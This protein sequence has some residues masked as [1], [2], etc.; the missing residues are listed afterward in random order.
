MASYRYERDIDPKDLKPYTERTYTRR[1]RWANWWDYNLK[2]V[3]I[4]GIALAFVLYSFIGHY[5]FTVHPDYNVGVVSPY[6]LPEDTTNALQ[7]AL[8]AYG[9]DLNGD[10]QVVVTVNVYTLNYSSDTETE[11][12]AYLT[13]AGTTKLAADLQSALSGIF[14][15]YDPAGFEESTGT[16][17]YLDGSLPLAESDDDWWNMVYRWTD[18]PVLTGLDLGS[19]GQDAAQASSGDS[20][21]YLSHFYVG[22]RGV[23]SEAQAENLEGT[24]E[25]W[26]KLIAGAV[27][28]VSADDAS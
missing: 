7:T 21:E 23:W 8:A 28:T 9:E 27:S 5:F 24:D 6:Y 20:Q 18:C 16:F 22:R 19:Y 12:D 3:I 10:G 26:S 4:G 2:W 1:E 14:I 17:A 13:M 25:L 11:S 15:V